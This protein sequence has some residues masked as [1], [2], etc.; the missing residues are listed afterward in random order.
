VA[1]QAQEP[2]DCQVTATVGRTVYPCRIHD[3]DGRHHFAAHWPNACRAPWC[4]LPRGHREGLHDIPGGKPVLRDGDGQLL[5]VLAESSPLPDQC[6]NGCQD[7][8]WPDGYRAGSFPDDL[9]GYCF[10][11][12]FWLEHAREAN[13][14]TVITDDRGNLERF[15]FDP[16]KPFKD[17]SRSLLGMSG[18]RFT[19]QFTDGRAVETNDLWSSG[20]IPERLRDLFPVNAHVTSHQYGPWKKA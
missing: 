10:T 19:I 4:R 17:C 2:R 18:H 9:A 11:C 8:P 6:A 20:V 13:A 16:R 5:A 1:D 3:D 7:K 15:Q 14:G 12:A